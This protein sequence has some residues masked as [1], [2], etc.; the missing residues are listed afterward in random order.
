MSMNL[1]TEGRHC[2]RLLMALI[3][4][5]LSMAACTAST[6][7]SVKSS[8]ATAQAWKLALGTLR[9]EATLQAVDSNSAEQLLPLWQLMGELST[10][11]AAAPQELFAVVDEIQTTM[12]AEQV[13]AID[14]MALS[15]HDF[16][17]P[18]ASADASSASASSGG[19]MPI[20]A[21]VGGG[22][23]P[24]GGGSMPGG[25]DM[26]QGQNSGSATRGATTAAASGIYQQV[27]SLLQRKLQGWARMT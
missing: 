15:A 16:E 18:A 11:S 13:D 1:T 17:D 19:G 24:D 2:A 7:A 8:A 6:S 27:I 12:T 3:A 21:V 22:A 20:K 10:N 26:P 9:L 14:E 25:G 5:P 4:L 23:P